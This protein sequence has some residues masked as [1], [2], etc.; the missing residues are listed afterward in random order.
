MGVEPPVRRSP[1]S[2]KG[3]GGGWGSTGTSGPVAERLPK[4]VL[5]AVESTAV[6][7]T[8]HLKKVDAAY[9]L[10]QRV[11]AREALLEAV[12]MWSPEDYDTWRALRED[13]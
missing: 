3:S 11:L 6:G 5:A 8:H 13:S 4:M 2:Q 12:R 9:A 1:S 7:L 10:D